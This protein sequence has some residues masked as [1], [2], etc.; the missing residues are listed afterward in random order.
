MGDVATGFNDNASR[1]L[2]IEVFFLSDLRCVRFSLCSFRMG[3]VLVLY[4]TKTENTR[5]VATLVAEGAR[6]IDGVEVRLK[7]VE[8]AT[9]E[10][11]LWCDGLAVGAPTHMGSIPWEMKRFWD[12]EMQPHWGEIDGKL[13]CA[14]ATEGGWGGGA[15]LN[16]QALMTVLMN[17]GFLVFGVTDYV[18][19]GFTLHY[20]A[21]IAGEPRSEREQEAP[22]RLG[23]RLAEWVA[24]FADGRKGEHPL[25][26]GR[27]RFPWGD[28]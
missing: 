24:V 4:F 25:R 11:V 18:A 1:G 5:S 12:V 9:A 3:K 10:D 13:G 2:T 6:V 7:S 20:G 21:T 22:R 14:F 27:P 26:S 17:Y 19:Q 16:C 15:E 28:D 8:E 23:R